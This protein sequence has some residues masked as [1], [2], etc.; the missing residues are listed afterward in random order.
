MRL[1]DKVQQI[2]TEIVD[3]TEELCIEM[4]KTALALDAQHLESLANSRFL[5]KEL[6]IAYSTWW[7]NEYYGYAH[8]NGEPPYERSIRNCRELLLKRGA[9]RWG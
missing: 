8:S 5:T 9:Q 7:I 6:D 2:A 4:E 1:F 3:G